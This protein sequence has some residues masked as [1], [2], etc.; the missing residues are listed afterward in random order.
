MSYYL[1][2]AEEAEPNLQGPEQKVWLDRLEAAHGNFRAA[3]YWSKDTDPE[4]TLRLAGALSQFWY[5]RGYL[6]EG[7][8]WLE[9]ALESD[10]SMPPAL[11]AKARYGV[12]ALAVDQSDFEHAGLMLDD[13]LAFYLES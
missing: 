8:R 11:I 10:G 5:I 4:A 13:N 3:L 2:L 9:L 1:A 12:A 6:T 7:R